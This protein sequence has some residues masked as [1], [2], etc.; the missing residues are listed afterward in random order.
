MKLRAQMWLVLGLVLTVA[1]ALDAVTSW[2]RIAR[3]QRV[4]QEVGVNVVRAMLMAM[5]RV[6]QQQFLDSGLPVNSKT[7]GFLP[8]H[9]MTRIAEDFGRWTDLGYRFNNVSDRPRNPRNRADPFEL[10]A[11]DFFRA[12]PTAKEHMQP[13]R[14]ADGKHWF[15]YTAPIWIE[16]YCLRCHGS[17][18]DAPETI[19][20]NYNASFGYLEGDLRGVMSIRL[21]LERH[22]KMLWDRWTSRLARNLFAFALVFVVLGLLMDRLVLRR[23]ERV[24]QAAQRVAAGDHE[25]RVTLTGSDEIAE[26]ADD[27]NRMAEEVAARERQLEQNSEEIKRHRDNLEWVVHQRTAQLEEARR[28][29]ESASRAKSAFLAN[30][31]HEIRTPLNAIIGFNYLLQREMH[32]PEQLGR[33]HKVNE[34][35]RH[36]LELVSDILDLSKIEAGYMKLEEVDFELD[37]QIENACALVAEHAR[38]QGL[39]FEIDIDPRLRSCGCLRGDATRLR[40][41]V[42]NYVGNALKFTPAGRIVLRVMPIAESEHDVRVRIEVE[43]T[44]IGIA[45]ADLPR[46]FTTFEQAD[47]SPMRRF[48]GTGLGLAINKHLAELMGGEVGVQSAP[49]VGSCFWITLRLGKAAS[50]PGTPIPDGD[51]QKEL[52]GRHYMAGVRVL[53]AEDNPVNREVAVDLLRA[54]G[55][56]PVVAANGAE[57]LALAEKARFDLILMDVQMPEMDGLDATRAIRRLPGYAQTPILAMTANVFVED[58]EQCIAAGMN[59]HIAKPVAPELLYAKLARWLPLTAITAEPSTPELAPVPAPSPVPPPPDETALPDIPGLDVVQGLKSVGGRIPS[60]RR[61]LNMFVE[62][63]GNTTS[64]LRAVLVA[65]DTEHGRRLA[66]TLKG[67][68]GALGAREVAACALAVEMAFKTGASKSEM[69]AALEH[70]DGALGALLAALASAGKGV[71]Q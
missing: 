5:R 23:L 19:R 71:A 11:M 20:E 70:L 32:D 33:I 14:D 3:E 67:A 16:K 47:N 8:A 30:M 27:F 13:I 42:L 12:N 63:H 28:A 62:H 21:P 55:I 15:H 22:E 65:G 24:R 29:A 59:D 38:A 60:Y 69:D 18:E 17:E 49:G 39:A 61:L 10:A 40:Q 1:I 25:V 4:E 9:S 36:L 34:S 45:A 46:L 7:I 58:R 56:A 54:V 64:H 51:L 68:A 52:Q 26:L 2:Q 35:A 43:D 41:A 37:R 50:C 31:S 44:G 6:Y 53:L 48:G 57:A 66:H